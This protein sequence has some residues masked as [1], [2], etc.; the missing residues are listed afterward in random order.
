VAAQ[1][2]DGEGGHHLWAAR[3]DRE[4]GDVF[5]LQDELSRQ[6]ATV[7]APEVERA[8]I[9]RSASKRTADLD[10]WDCYLRGMALLQDFTK[11]RNAEARAMFERAIA[12][13]PGYAD[14][15]AG[16][17]TGH[18]RDVLLECA[19][20]REESVRLG[21]AAARRAV[22][23]DPAS[24]VAHAALATAH[25]WRNEH[26]ASLA[27]ARL[28]VELNPFDAMVLHA[29]GNK[30]DLAGDPEGIARMVQAQRLN[31]DD[32]DRH[33]HLCFLARAYVNARQH[34]RA[35]E[36]ARAALRKRP[37]YPHAHYILAV[38][39]GHLGRVEEACAA[40]AACEAAQPGFVAGRADWRP[41]LDEASNAYLHQGLRKLSTS[42][43]P[44]HRSS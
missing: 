1:L 19:A 38:A 12:I 42:A 2:I 27:E 40:L 16:L 10:A 32:P 24:S 15:H 33:S 26:E 34:D 37:D 39:L 6:I 5:A 28:A 17:A 9:R 29:L 3:Y 35:V 25:L 4:I 43:K 36:C 31:P 14:A 13:D 44:S 20:D 41:Y 11:A 18:L 23:V 22:A 30:S 7:I 21:M 8:G